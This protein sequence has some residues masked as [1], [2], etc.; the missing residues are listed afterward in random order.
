LKILFLTSEVAPFAKTGGLADVA[1]SLPKALAALGHDVRVMM[2]AYASIERALQDGRWGLH[3]VGPT[4][5]VSLLGG[6]AAGVLETV[7][8]GTTVPVHFVAE[9]QIFDRPNLYGYDDDPYRFAFFCRAALQWTVEL[10]GWRPDIVHAHDWHAAP[11]VLWLAIAGA[12]DL[13]YRDLPTVFTIHNLL[14]QGRTTIDILRYVG[15]RADRLY[16]EGPDEVNLM[17]RGIYHATMVNTV[18]PTYAREILTPAGG[19]GLDGLLRHRGFDVHGI[20]NGLDYDIWNPAT[21]SHLTATYDATSIER[22]LA[23]KRALQKRLKLPERDGVPVVAMV[24]RLDVQK[25]VDLLAA[26]ATR[27]L[28]GGD[29]DAQLVVLGSGLPEFE[30]AL[31]RLAGAHPDRMSAVLRYDPAL[32]P[33]IYAGSDIFLMPSRFEPCG[34]GQLIAMRYGSVP[35]VR[36]TGGL[37]DTVHQGVT[38]FSFEPYDA[39]AFWDA[40]QRALSVYRGDPP[41]WREIQHGGMASDFSWVSSAHGYEQLYGWAVSRVRGR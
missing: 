17:A 2:P 6:I 18:S 21:D 13:R 3:A 32:A 36:A 41:A 19:M 14:H 25:G 40:L 29:P 8:P 10:Q 23:N 26:V 39:D 11:A 22:R 4:L 1:G 20:L 15:V 7:L 33:L 34:L 35:V 16:D 24:S 12:D 38:G 28:S 37:V 5:R 9:R 30:T 27:L 31:R